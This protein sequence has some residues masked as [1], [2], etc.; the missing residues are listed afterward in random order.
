VQATGAAPHSTDLEPLTG[1]DSNCNSG[2]LAR[3][4]MRRTSLKPVVAIVKK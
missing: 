2:A 1:F 4:M 3:F